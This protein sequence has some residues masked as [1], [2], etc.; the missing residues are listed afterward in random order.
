MKI[1]FIFSFL[2]QPSRIIFIDNVNYSEKPRKNREKLTPTDFTAF[3]SSLKK[4]YESGPMS[5]DELSA[6]R[7]TFWCVKVSQIEGL[8]P[9]VFHPPSIWNADDE[10]PNRK[11]LG[12]SNMLEF[13][14][15]IN[16]VIASFIKYFWPQLSNDITKIDDMSRAKINE[17]FPISKI[18]VTQTPR[19]LQFE[20]KKKYS[21]DVKISQCLISPQK[22]TII[23]EKT[24][25]EW[26]IISNANW[27]LLGH[28][29]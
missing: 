8:F 25:W 1:S 18:K 22:K 28:L 15:L 17:N 13:L 4:L 23:E 10:T 26:K 14:E 29:N 6:T 5:A 19:E 3:K 9:S 2:T 16:D 12:N 7:L 24:S 27:G 21:E 20:L 11:S